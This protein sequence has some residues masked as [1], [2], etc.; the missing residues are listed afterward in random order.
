MEKE[1][2]KRHSSKK[3][4]EFSAPAFTFANPTLDPGDYAIPFAF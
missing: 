4:I 2:I 1:D 3:I